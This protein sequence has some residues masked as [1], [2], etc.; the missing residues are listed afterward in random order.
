MIIQS[1]YRF[2]GVGVL[3]LWGPV[4]GSFPPTGARRAF[5]LAEVRLPLGRSL[6]G[7]LVLLI[8]GHDR[9]APVQPELLSFPLPSPASF[10][11]HALVLFHSLSFLSPSSPAHIF[12]FFLSAISL[13]LLPS[14]FPFLSLSLSFLL[15]DWGWVTRGLQLEGTAVPRNYISFYYSC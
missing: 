5:D 15:S 11:P 4:R 2:W 13:P 3:N 1:S 12:S 8:A 10:S 6:Q 14:F 7:L 9:S